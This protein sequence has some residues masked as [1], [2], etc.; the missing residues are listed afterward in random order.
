MA[1]LHGNGVTS[2]L[3]LD[4]LHKRA[5]ILY[6]KDARVCE[7]FCLNVADASVAIETIAHSQIWRKAIVGKEDINISALV[8]EAG[9]SDWL[10]RGISYIRDDKVCPF[11]QQKT[12]T[13]EFVERLEQ[14]FSD[15]YE[16]GVNEVKRL[17]QEYRDKTITVLNAINAASQ[18]KEKV[19]IGALD[20]DALRGKT[21]L[22]QKAIDSN[23]NAMNTKANEPSR[24]VIVESVLPILNEITSLFAAADNAIDKHNNMV[25]NRVTEQAKLRNDVLNYC[26]NE[27]KDL[28]A[29]HKE[30]IENLGKAVKGISEKCQR[31]ETERQQKEK[32]I[33]DK[34]KN[35]KSVMPAIDAMNKALKAYGFT[36]FS[37]VPSSG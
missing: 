26:A 25:N 31:L 10:K 1:A 33:A 15:E 35:I 27:K 2:T 34:E 30:K 32:N 14:F 28:I 11:C 36:S 3:T 4:D 29:S 37:I 8:S 18:A 23:I 13:K 6:D 5:S 12:I 22:L 9:Y 7:K 21:T 16:K 19:A 17:S 24:R 20:A